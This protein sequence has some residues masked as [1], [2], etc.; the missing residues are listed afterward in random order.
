LW[1]FWCFTHARR[2]HPFMTSQRSIARWP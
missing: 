2:H 1:V